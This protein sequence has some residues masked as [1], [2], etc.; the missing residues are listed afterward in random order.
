MLEPII[1]NIY[2]DVLRLKILSGVRVDDTAVLA[3]VRSEET[4]N[5][6]L[7]YGYKT[8]N[9]KIRHIKVEIKYV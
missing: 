5:V 4:L 8:K 6:I 1:L 9:L 3:T 7:K 2:Y